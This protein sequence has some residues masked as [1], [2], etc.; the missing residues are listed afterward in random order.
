MRR[1]PAVFAGAASHILLTV[2]G[3][4]SDVV[5]LDER[6]DAG[7]GRVPFAAVESAPTSLRVGN[8]GRAASALDLQP[9]P[10]RSRSPRSLAALAWEAAVVAPPRPTRFAGTVARP[11]LAVMLPRGTVEE[12]APPRAGRW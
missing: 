7:A 10:N 12:R 5:R 6:L 1:R 8:G 2:R 4:L 3:P 9:S 11:R